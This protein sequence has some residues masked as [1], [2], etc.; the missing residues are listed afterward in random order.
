MSI[1]ITGATGG[2]GRRVVEVL[3]ERGVAA[4][5]VVAC[6]RNPQQ[7][8]ELAALGVRA[9]AID[10][11]RPETL[12]A[13]FDGVEQVL[14]VSGNVPGARVA[15]HSNVIDAARAA[16]VARILYTSI[17]R[18]DTTTNV[19]APDHVATEALIRDSGLTATILRNGWY[20]DGYAGQV[21]DAIRDGALSAAAG[22]GVVA[23]APRAEYAEAAA[24]ALL[25]P[26]SAGRVYELC[27]DE[28]WG[29]ADLAAIASLH[30]GRDIPYRAVSADER[31]EQLTA[32]GLDEGLAG[33][34]VRL[35]TDV[36]DGVLASEGSHD[37]SA[38][39]GRPT[40][41]IAQTVAAGLA[42]QS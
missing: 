13:A 36:A 16:G 37:L 32:A 41:P 25:D 33:F 28:E 22:D 14:L 38:L 2:L 7:L 20:A 34:L 40:T 11:D 26:A 19:L 5:D 10:Y 23:S 15:Q 18:A 24:A 1:A 8:A 30:A 39:L 29:Y 31:L 35:E 12:A 9:T 6:G 17:L 3:L 21:R 42:E 27:G 4:G